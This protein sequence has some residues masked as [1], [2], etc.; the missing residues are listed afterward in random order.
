MI[1]VRFDRPRRIPGRTAVPAKI[2][3]EDV[4][5]CQP[6]LGELPEP[7]TVSGDAVKADD[8]RGVAVAP[9][10]DVELHGRGMPRPY[11]LPSRAST[12]GGSVSRQSPTRPTS[13]ALKMGAWS[14][15]FSATMT[16]ALTEPTRCSNA[17]RTQMAR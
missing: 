9:L 2:R 13:A 11:T 1:E 7:A 16:P 17:P 14:F 6:L 10:M 4:R 12:S 15:L 5:P 8:R 3:S